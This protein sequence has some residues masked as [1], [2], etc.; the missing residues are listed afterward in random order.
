MTRDIEARSRDI[1]KAIPDLSNS[2]ALPG[3]AT[4]TATLDTRFVTGPTLIGK[5]SISLSRETVMAAIEFWLS[6]TI[7]QDDVTV[8][9]FD[10]GVGNSIIQ[11]GDAKESY[12][13]SFAM[14]PR[15]A[16]NEQP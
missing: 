8:N 10:H 3:G 15:D 1:F 14:K 7:F 12:V 5:T 2:I 6:S 11:T 9:A 13:V 16:Q 4:L